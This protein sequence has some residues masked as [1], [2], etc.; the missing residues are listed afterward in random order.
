MP[1]T[2]QTWR[3]QKL[4]HVVFGLSSLL[5]LVAT[6]WMLAAD[7]NREWKQYQ[8]DFRDVE[9]WTANSRV[10]EQR[11]AAFEEETNKL[12]AKLLDSL[13]AV[14]EEQ[15][16]ESFKQE[17]KDDAERRDEK[18]PDLSNIDDKLKE[19]NDASEKDKPEK[20][21]EFVETLGLYVDAARFRE[22]NVSTA[23]KFK[24]ADYDVARSNYEL[25]IG[26]SKP[27]AE[28]DLLQADVDK[29]KSEL[30]KL[31]EEVE[32]AKTHRKELESILN[33]ITVGVEQSRKELAD[34]KGTVG[35][36]ET[37]LKE[38]EPS[39]MKDVLAMPIIDAFGRPLK[40]EQVWLPKLTINNNFRDVARFDRCVTCH[41][42][43][44][45]T[46]PGSAVD[47][48]YQQEKNIELT[49]AVP[50]AKAVIEKKKDKDGNEDKNAKEPTT[51]DYLMATYGLKL[52]DKG[53]LNESDVTVEVIR[54]ESPAALAKLMVGDVITYIGDAKLFSVKD[55]EK[56]LLEVVKWGQPLKLV[57]R[58]GLPQ[59][60]VSHPRL[61]LFVGSMSPH[62][63]QDMGCTICHEGQGSATAFKWSS[64]TPNDP[65]QADDWKKKYG[66]FNNHHWI[67]PQH[68]K[69]FAESSCLKCHHEVAELA[70]SER[71]PDPPA[72]QLMAG[73]EIIREYGC[74]GCHEINGYDGPNRRVGP[75]M[76]AE[77]NYSAAAQALL[78]LGSLNEQQT[79]WARDVAMQPSDDT[80]RH[81]LL[82]SLKNPKA[83]KDGNPIQLSTYERKLTNLLDDVETPGKLR[84][85]GPSLRHVADKDDYDFLYSWVRN[86]KDFRPTTKMPRFFGLNDHLDGKG[87]EVAERYEPVEIRGVVE[88]LLAKSQPY[89]FADRPKSVTE[90]PDLDRGKRLFETRGCLA[91]HTHK[92]FPKS[93][94]NQGPDLSRIG[95]KLGRENDKKGPQWLY[96][97]LR[98]PSSYHPRTLMPNLILDPL[99][100]KDEKG[101]E[102]GKIT[103]PAADIAVFLL[104]SGTDWKIEGVPARELTS[105]EREALHDLAFEHLKT[106]FTK[107]ET[108][109]FLKTGI[110]ESRA[111]ELKGD[112]VELLGEMS[113]AKLLNY[114]GRRTISKYGCSGCHDIPGFEDAK[115]I[116]T[117]LADWGRKGAD[118]LAFEQ[119]SQF[120]ASGHGG[121]NHGD[122]HA[123]E[124]HEEPAAE[125]A[126]DA[127]HELDYMSMD[128]DE[129]FFMEKLMGHERTGF[130]W[131][132]LRAPRSYDFKKT[133]NK[134]YNERLRMPQFGFNEKQIE[135]VI[136]FVLGLVAEPPATQYVFQPTPRR[137][138]IVEGNKVIDKFN[139]TGCHAFELERWKLSFKPDEIRP[140]A[141][142][143]EYAFL[144][145]H[146]SPAEV[147]ASLATDNRGRRHAMI[148][149]TAAVDENGV[150]IRRDEDGA[151]LEPDDTST[152]GF[153]TIQPW[154]NTLVNG[155]VRLAGVQNIA[156]PENAV[157]RLYPQTGGYLP[158][159]IY[160][161]VVAYEKTINPQTKAAD[162]AWAWLPPPLVHEGNKVQSSW[163]HD[164]LLEPYPIRPAVILRMPKFNMSPQEA[165]TLVNYFAAVDNAEYPYQFDSRTKNQPLTSDEQKMMTNAMKIIVDNNYCVKCHLVGDFSPA[166]S[167]RAKGPHLDLVYKR[168]RADYLRAWIANPKRLLPYTAMPVNI[169]PDK[170][171]SQEL[172]PGTGLQQIDGLVD[173]L[174]NYDRFTE[175]KTPVSPMVKPVAVPP[176]AA[177]PAATPGPPVG[178]GE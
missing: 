96:S 172:F 25:A 35:R 34:H 82:A 89:Q 63:L 61:D 105:E 27:Q 110:P 131:Q 125:E 154:K 129:G 128:P 156:V 40:V 112:E 122:G 13:K 165:S 72:P 100:V 43:I 32:L 124:E 33:L 70:P 75:D 45:K 76:R 73:F 127:H 58:R 91:C 28:L 137:Q 118:K 17:V 90:D 114:V 77:P 4:L 119:I 6:I 24:A 87:L 141:P 29:V 115:P 113:E 57:V 153:L 46:A 130:I 132:K 20:R 143:N 52:A 120:I 31:S 102:T 106:A 94:M 11:N 97:W 56:Y 10:Q 138:A 107:K 147:Q 167:D 155:E 134:G 146:F 126:A 69:R 37:A 168:F 74:Y 163:L 152:P 41:Q 2:E 66:W 145:A 48:G 108:E 144:A 38:R 39:F 174:M 159:Y 64:H 80:A 162:E 178:S 65:I 22:N 151:P 51:A 7:H 103:D 12:E 136:T 23:K 60:F 42:A 15:L 117:G 49:L 177:A 36:L 81:D 95:A 16:V 142:V 30:D 166:G 88:F 86:P 78:A 79:D 14:P 5:M 44:E 99:P 85:L 149:G 67:F 71:F 111:S 68:A 176:A 170:P 92:D 47:P 140:P 62:K 123:K 26:N 173:L 157:E 8:R 109:T 135:Q 116:G 93:Q 18:A 55:A 150:V 98:N 175:S 54:P 104:S 169:P 84:K 1:A 101:V 3:D 164:F 21:D 139:C 161:S 19:F 148:T 59:P 50:D 158:Q 83:D 133:E 121:G 160:P 9:T 53:L 171:V